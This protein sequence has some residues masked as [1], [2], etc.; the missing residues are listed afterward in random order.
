MM[1]EGTRPGPGVRALFASVAATLTL[2]AH[3]ADL[4]GAVQEEVPP[5]TVGAR[6]ELQAARADT[7]VPFRH[8]DHEL[9]EC[10][11]CHET[12]TPTVR[13][14]RQWCSDCHH[15]RRTA[16]ACTTCHASRELGE[17]TYAVHRTME[18][19]VG[20]SADRALPF[21]HAVHESFSC[22]RCHGEGTSPDASGLDCTSCHEDHHSLDADCTACHRSAPED[23][24]PVEAHLT[25]QGSGCHA[26]A[27]VAEPPSRDR[28][29]C[30]ACHQELADHE[31]GGQCADCHVLPPPRPVSP[32]GGQR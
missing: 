18:F 9:L 17:T 4:S 11:A 31:P 26:S 8:S 24:H 1:P 6:I 19:T 27:P 25:C 20:T 13:A 28:V 10:L 12:G 29:L 22:G 5:D 32:D 14:N 30:L 23:A 3:T 15:S 21:Q 16:A 2:A 7:T